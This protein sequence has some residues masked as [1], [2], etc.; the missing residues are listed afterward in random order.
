MQF[1]TLTPLVLI[2]LLLYFITSKILVEAR[3]RRFQQQNDCLPPRQTPQFDRIL[4]LDLLLKG[5]KNVKNRRMVE[6]MYERFLSV[7]FTYSLRLGGETAITT[8]EPENV[9]A[10][11]A[12]KFGDFDLGWK[13]RRAFASLIG[14]G[15]FAADGAEW[16]FARTLI[17]PA[18]VRSQVADLGLFED[19]I[20]NFIHHLPKDGSTG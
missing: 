1:P 16:H 4:G 13:R 3:R 18:F 11:L 8:I 7:G 6:V 5:M 9:Q 17:R 10:M 20:A 12:H 19:H 14:D 15:I 2:L